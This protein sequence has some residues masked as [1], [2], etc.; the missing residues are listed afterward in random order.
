MLY[1]WL[2]GALKKSL[3]QVFGKN[4]PLEEVVSNFGLSETLGDPNGEMR[5]SS[6]SKRELVA[7]ITVLL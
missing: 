2:D 7:S 4:V 1:L 6:K 3:V 5:V